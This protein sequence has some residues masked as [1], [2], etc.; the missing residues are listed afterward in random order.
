MVVIHSGKNKNIRSGSL[1][2]ISYKANN[3][4][5]YDG[6][7]TLYLQAIFYKYGYEHKHRIERH[8]FLVP[9]ETN[10]E[11]SLKRAKKIVNKF[12][13]KALLV[14]PCTKAEDVNSYCLHQYIAWSKSLLDANRHLLLMAKH[15]KD[16]GME[17]R[18]L[19][20]G[21]MELLLYLTDHNFAKCFKRL[22]CMSNKERVVLTRCLRIL[23][24]HMIKR[25][26]P[27]VLSAFDGLFFTKVTGQLKK[28]KT[29]L[30]KE[31]EK[32]YARHR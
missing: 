25:S 19:L 4:F 24:A 29:D 16:R 21:R 10:N 14:A 8:G 22:T 26:P 9:A 15:D 32:V 17:L 3:R 11:I 13:K 30:M 31:G 28:Y 27:I 7:S 2:F 18:K 5:V 12:N 1:G 20:K 23:E 6:Y